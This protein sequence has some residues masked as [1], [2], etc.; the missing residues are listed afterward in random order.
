MDSLF[1]EQLRAQ[2]HLYEQEQAIQNLQR[3]ISEQSEYPVTTMKPFLCQNILS[4]CPTKHQ[5][6]MECY[7]DMFLTIT[8]GA[9]SL[10]S[11]FIKQFRYFKK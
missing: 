2:Q 8:G 9:V 11:D 10:S 1:Q 7:S 3:Q 5:G 6:I 4:S